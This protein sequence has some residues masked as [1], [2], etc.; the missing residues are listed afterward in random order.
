MSAITFPRAVSFRV[1]SALWPR[2]CV[3]A[4]LVAT[5]VLYVWGLD[6][7]GWAN[8]YYSAA[9]LAGTKSWTAFFFGSLD[10]GNFITVD[11]PPAALWLMELSARLFGLNSWSLLLPE[12][13][14]GALCVLLVVLTVR[15][16]FGP[17][18]G[19]VAG[20]VTAP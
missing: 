15:R 3:A 18:A 6:R 2:I 5:F 10:A 8:Q 12:A 16:A 1:S 19:L 20:A 14:A 9:V 4:L 11:K 17:L 13:L 7:S